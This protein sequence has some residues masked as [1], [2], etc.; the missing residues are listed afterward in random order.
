[1]IRRALCLVCLV[2]AGGVLAADVPPLSVNPNDRSGYLP[3][4]TPLPSS[5]SSSG[6]L[7]TAVERLRKE[8]AALESQRRQLELDNLKG[9]SADSAERVKL[10]LQ[11]AELVQ[12]LGEKNARPTTVIREPAATGTGLLD[13]LEK[14]A[15]PSADRVTL[16]Q[17]QYRARNF[18]AALTTIDAIER[19]ALLPRDRLWLDYLKAGCL[20]Q[21]GKTSEAM[22]LY[23][24]VGESKLDPF[25]SETAV[26]Q[27]S[28]L[29][30]KQELQTRL[31]TLRAK[32][33]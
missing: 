30:W 4:P 16:A 5:M 14:S 10:R 1:M 18:D 15:A 26:W 11:I 9:R 17:T 7:D 3:P 8:R 2:F 12:R 29:R 21:Q 23:R 32:T 20:R 28:V 31:D 24:E 22:A 27:V 6:G 19:G 33:P 13:P 25:L